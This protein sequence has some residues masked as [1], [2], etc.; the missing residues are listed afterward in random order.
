MRRRK[1]N[2]TLWHDSLKWRMINHIVA[3]KIEF[4]HDYPTSGMIAFISR[5]IVP[6]SSSK[7]KTSRL[8]RLKILILNHILSE[9]S[10]FY[11]ENQLE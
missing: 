7:F 9:N 6:R 5:M 8:N 3:R 4:S 11:V 1:E 2:S 10:Q